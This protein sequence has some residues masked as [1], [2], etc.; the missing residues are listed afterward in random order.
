[1]RIDSPIMTNTKATGSFSGSFFGAITA[2]SFNSPGLGIV[3]GSDQIV[4]SDTTGYSTFS[5]SLATDIASNTA[6]LAALNDTYTTD[7][8]LNASSSALISGYQLADSALSSSLAT[9]ITSEY[10][11]A[12][13]NLS[14]SLAVDIA[15]NTVKVGYTDSLVKTKLNVENVVSASS[16]SSP[17]QGTVRA[18]INGVNTD[19]DTGL[20]V[21]D[22]PTFANLVVTGNLTVEGSRTELQVTELNVEDKNITIA[23]G[24][25]DSAAADG[26]GITIAGANESITWNHANSRFNISDDLNIEGNI[27]LTGTVDGVDIAQ[28]STDV[29]NLNN[30]F[31]T[32]AELNASSS[33][34]ITGYGNADSALSSSLATAITSEYETADTNLSSSLALDIATNA[35]HISALH[36]FT[37]SLNNT[38]AT[39][40]EL[41]ASS[42]ALIVAYG[43]ADTNL[44]SSLASAL[45]SEYQT[46]DTNLSSSLATAITSEYQTADT[47]LSS[48]LALGISTNAGNIATNAGHISALHSF[49]ASLNNTFATDAE[50][51]ASSSALITAYG[52]ADSALSSSLATAITSEY[53]T[54]DTN[55]SSSLALSIS[56]NASHI[57]ALHS[58][59]ASLNDTFATDAELNA[60]SSALITAYEN[61]DSALSSSLAT[62]ITSE[63][64]TADT[65]LSSSLASSIATNA[66]NISTNA[67]HIT[68]LHSF[69]ASLNDTF[70]TD[71]ELNAS[72]SAL[73]TAYGNADSAL[74][75]SLASALTSEYETADTNL[76][77]SL[78]SAISAIDTA[79]PAITSNGTVPSLNTG[80]DAGEIRTLID[81]DQAGTDNSTDVTLEGSYDYITIVGQTITRNQITNDDLAG[82]IANAK[83]TNSSITINGS[84]VSLGGTRTLVTDDIAEDGSPV[85]LWYTDARVKTKLNAE[86]VISSSAQI[87]HDATTN[88]VP[89][90]HIDHTT[91]SVIAGN[92]LTGGGTIAANRTLN[93]NPGDGI[94]I[95]SDAV[96]VDS[97][98]A[99]RNAANTFSSDQTFTN[100]YVNGTGS[101]AYIASITGSAKIIGDAYIILNADTPSE[102]YSGIKVIDSGSAGATG[103]LEYDSVANHWFYESTSEGYASIIMSGPKATRGSLTIPTSGSLVVA[104]GNH[105]YTSQIKNLNNRVDISTNTYVTGSISATGDIIAYASSDER[106]KDNIEPITDAL[107]KVEKIRGVSF[108][109]NDKQN[110]YEGHDIGVIAQEIEAVLP[111]LVQTRDNGYKAV[112]YEKLTA[113]LIQAVKELSARVKELESK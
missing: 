73:I 96:A 8:E 82:S 55:L 97:T 5:S 89:N 98:V 33:A 59:T 88:F 51:N 87:D 63:Y 32:D 23:S 19:V 29:S 102:R 4:I 107:D 64:E 58:F 99:R 37:A 36:S 40:A 3:S 72:S 52:N 39:D 27:T 53:Q 46:G 20:Q 54:A 67:G 78:A 15:L 45:T 94:Q 65:N 42:S 105:L 21:G 101:F 75:S 31:A 79:V 92:G 28:L 47:N 110:T 6:A 83:L 68:A 111:E 35:G 24:A 91:V 38:F 25:A 12:D 103:S 14:S 9:A 77:S 2:E 49:T 48:S 1:M 18:T 17:S 84:A 26:A 50:L 62:A 112:K 43:N 104:A 71:A 106:L 76:S 81:V 74:S 85:N 10:E 90:E 34:L 93:V 16:F 66:G 56:A 100:I 69:T 95:V 80:I 41:N 30:T 70:A 109:W 57:S 113:V 22:S 7:A 60:S 44:S 61:A 11:T 86:G 108:N 13:T